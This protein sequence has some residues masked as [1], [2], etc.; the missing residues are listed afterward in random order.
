MASLE[1]GEE[2][3][4]CRSLVGQRG[5][6]GCDLVVGIA[7]GQQ[8]AER[9]QLGP[10]PLDRLVGLGE[11]LEVRHD[12][13]GPFRGVEG[14]EHVIA[15]EI[16][17]VADRFHGHRLMEQLHRLLG[18]D[19]ETA[20]EILA[21]VREAVV[22]LSAGRTQPPA[23]RGH[24]GAEVGEVTRHRQR[25]VRGHVEPVG[26]SCGV[27]AAQPEHLGDGDGRV[28]PLVGEH[29][30]DHAVLRA[31]AQRNRPGGAGDLVALGL[32]V[33][34]HVRAQRPLSGVRAGGLVVRNP[35]GRQQQRGDRI[36]DGGLPGTDVAGQQRVAR[37]RVQRP[38]ALVEC[39]PVVQFQ[40]GQ[41][42]AAEGLVHSASL[43]WRASSP[44][45]ASL[46]SKS[47]SHW[48]STK[49][50]RIRRTS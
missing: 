30:E 40:A 38:D 23:Q 6:L 49:A 9:G 31:V 39:A 29:T 18:L 46:V 14:L 8:R 7:F 34:E 1:V 16:G 2:I 22:D 17:E 25:L 42:E 41:P 13:R 4:Q 19:A 35:V 11:I 50:L 27:G 37:V 24:V 10:G 28:V 33:A 26:L 15:D 32:V 12:V 47:A 3:F 43:V 21:V 48:P 20:A 5:Y 44:Y 36:D 45:S